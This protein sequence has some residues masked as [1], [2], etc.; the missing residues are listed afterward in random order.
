MTAFLNSVCVQDDLQV[1]WAYDLV[2]ILGFRSRISYI[3][4][5]QTQVQRVVSA[6][7][8]TNTASQLFATPAQTPTFLGDMHLIKYNAP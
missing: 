1:F 2:C 8:S 3:S 7:K 4:D 6:A 5:E